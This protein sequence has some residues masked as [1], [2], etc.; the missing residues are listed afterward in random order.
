MA[1]DVADGTTGVKKALRHS[2]QA[3]GAKVS[4]HHRI[5]SDPQTSIILL[6]P[7]GAVLYSFLASTF[8]LR[9]LK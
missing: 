1:V 4:H 8:L 7:T 6:L 5:V 3:Q 2:N 9:L